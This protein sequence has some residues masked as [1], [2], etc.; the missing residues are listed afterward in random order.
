[1]RCRGLGTTRVHVGLSTKEIV[2]K[3]LLM[4]SCHFASWRSRYL[5]ILGTQPKQKMK[6]LL[7]KCNEKIGHILR[8]I[9]FKADRKFINRILSKNEK[10]LLTD[11]HDAQ[12]I[13]A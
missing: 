12:V 2:L 8:R 4:F 9:F 13:L 10:I 3:M 6:S 5:L 11:N 7:L 1:M